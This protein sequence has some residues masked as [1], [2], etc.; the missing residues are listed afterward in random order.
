[1]AIKIFVVIKVC[2][3]FGIIERWGNESHVE[4]YIEV[5]S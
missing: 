3:E 1:V 5:T 2:E 4:E